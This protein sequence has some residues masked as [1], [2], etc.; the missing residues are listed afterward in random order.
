MTSSHSI[1][2]VP[3]AMVVTLAAY[4]L[5]M[6][7]WSLLETVL[8]VAIMKRLELHPLEGT[9]V[10]ASLGFQARAS[11]LRSFL[12]LDASPESKDAIKV[13]N[14]A[15]Q[16]ANR[17]MIIHGQVFAE[18]ETLSFVY[19]KVDQG[20]T[21]KRIKVDSTSMLQRASR[22]KESIIRLQSLL[23]I[24]DDDLHEFGNIGQRLA[25]GSETLSNPPNSKT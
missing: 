6:L 1:D 3:D 14:T 20:L 18:G 19:R 9:I 10:T 12:V 2:D 25:I 7:N 8:E 23:S 5:F 24:S 13:I 22:L 21:A 16:E 11:I 15:T 17:N 4:G